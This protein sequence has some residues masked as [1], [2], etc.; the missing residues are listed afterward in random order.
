[1]Y[2]N[3][4]VGK[5]NYTGTGV[6]SGLNV[7]DTPAYTQGSVRTPTRPMGWIWASSRSAL[8]ATTTTTAR[9]HNQAY[10]A[11]FNNVNL[12]FNYT[13]RNHSMFDQSKISFSINNLLNNENIPDISSFNSPV[14]AGTSAYL[15]TTAASPLDQ[16]N[17]TSGRSFMVSFKIGVFPHHGE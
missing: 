1:M 15:A 17:L 8:A 12:F 6:P 3:G 2:A 10:V 4:T 14:P 11:P 7:A 9:Y 5:A 13:I 16:L